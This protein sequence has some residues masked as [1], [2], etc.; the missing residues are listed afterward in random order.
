MIPLRELKTTPPTPSETRVLQALLL[1]LLQACLR[2]EGGNPGSELVRGLP[3]PLPYPTGA[4][5]AHELSYTSRPGRTGD[6]NSAYRDP[7]GLATS[8]LG[9]SVS[10]PNAEGTK[11][12]R[13]RKI[14]S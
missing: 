4:H 7:S 11:Q 3:S 5:R 8:G 14:N 9:R 12:A 10:S 6:H 2:C 13:G 1:L